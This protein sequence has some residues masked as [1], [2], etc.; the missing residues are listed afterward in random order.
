VLS[1][2]DPLSYFIDDENSTNLFLGYSTA[3]LRLKRQLDDMNFIVDINHPL[4]VYL[5]C[6]VGGGPG[7]IAFGL[8]LL[9][10]D[11][12][13]CFF[14][15]PTHSPCM[16]LGLLTELHENI[17]VSDFGIDNITQADGLAVGTPSGLVARTMQ[18][19]LSGVYTVEDNKLYML[20]SALIDSEDIHL[21]PSACAG[22][23]GVAELFVNEASLK[24]IE[25]HNLTH[26]MVNAIHIAWATGG[27]LV[28]KE[29]MDGYYEKGINLLYEKE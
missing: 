14:A 19:L 7:G 20:L 5:P 21:E 1:D 16:L 24:Y 12:V 11:N 3:A 27:S 9:F 26:K 17:S 2:K 22:I 29:V 28:P 18:N 25:T 23:S 8:K 4:F 10:K 13:H 6:G 15:E